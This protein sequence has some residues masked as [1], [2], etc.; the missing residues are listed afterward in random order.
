MKEETLALRKWLDAGNLLLSQSKEFLTFATDNALNI[1]ANRIPDKMLSENKG[2]TLVFAGQYSAGKSSVMKVLTDRQDIA[3]GEGITTAKANSYDWDGITII[4]TPGIHTEI[5][6]DHDEITYKAISEADLLVFVITNELFDDHLASHFRN[7]AIDRHKASEMMLVVNKMRRC[8]KGNTLEA[9]NII[10]EDL[11]K[12]LAPYSPED[13]HITFIDA[14]AALE[15]REEEDKELSEMLWEKSGIDSLTREMNNF[16]RDKGLKSRYTTALYTLEQ[17][18]QEAISKQ[19]GND[20]DLAGTEELLLQKR[21]RL[22]E[23]ESSIHLSADEE[24]QKAVSQIREIGRNEAEKIHAGADVELVNKE[25]ALAQK[26]V[27]KITEQLEHTLD[28]VIGRQIEGL[29][30]KLQALADSEFAKVLLPR[31]QQKIEQIPISQKNKNDIKIVADSASN[32]GKFLVKNASSQ[33]GDILTDFFRLNQ[34]S[35]TPVHQAI[36]NIGN[37]LG[38]KFKPWEAIRWANRVANL[39][40]VLLVAGS[41]V[42]FILLLKEDSDA[43]K[44]ENALRETRDSIRSGFNEAATITEMHFNE[45]TKVYTIDKISSEIANIDS[46]L[47]KL[48]TMHNEKD[49]VFKTLLELLEKTRSLIKQ[50]Q[51]EEN[52]NL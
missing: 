38:Y 29:N 40:R 42:Q 2:V 48:H 8:A 7:L 17:T 44:Q 51:E 33:T 3:I 6:P 9:Q 50:I 13:L 39:G 30:R 19:P 35:G 10:R 22:K 4:D 28:V 45:A 11:R 25:L 26:N 41:I 36:K 52:A 46:Q 32:L 15:S 27:E 37:V 24:I 14:K 1:L 34:S 31:L 16:I 18:L 5:H 23:T 43:Q 12:V 21:G 47:E 49:R 20:I